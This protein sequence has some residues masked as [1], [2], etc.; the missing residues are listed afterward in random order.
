MAQFPRP[1]T[2]TGPQAVVD[3]PTFAAFRDVPRTG[4]IYVTTEAQRRGYSPRAADGANLGQAMPDPDALPGAPPRVSELPIHDGDQEYAPVAGLWE[5]RE[6]IAGY[7]NELFR[8]G[9]GSKY[10]A[11][12]VAGS[13]GGRPAPTRGAP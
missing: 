9:R 2:G 12:N 1:K 3:G 7:Y 4:V 5:L 8:R 13:G 10:S 11:A 6:A